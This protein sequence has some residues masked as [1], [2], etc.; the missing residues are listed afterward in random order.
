MQ[1]SIPFAALLLTPLLA[2][3]VGEVDFTGKTCEQPADCP[4][5]YVCASGVC[6]KTGQD[7]SQADGGSV[8]AGKQN[9]APT[10]TDLRQLDGSGRAV[11]PGATVKASPTLAAAPIDP[12]GGPVRLE[13]EL[14]P[15]T[16][17]FT[18]TPNF[19][20][21]YATSGS[22]A[23]SLGSLEPGN[24]RWQARAV[25]AEGN[26]SAFEPFNG[27]ATAFT[28]QPH[29][30][31]ASLQIED[32]AAFARSSLVTLRLQASSRTGATITGVQLSNDNEQFSPI[33]PFASVRPGWKLEAGDGPRRVYARILDSAGESVVVEAAVVVDSTPPA[34]ALTVGDGT[35][36]ARVS[37]VS[38]LIDATDATSGLATMAFSNDGQGFSTP[39]PFEASATWPLVPGDGNRK[40]TVR[41]ADKAGNVAEASASVFFDA[42]PPTGTLTINGGAPYT[43]KRDV[44]LALAITDASGPATVALSQDGVTFG[45]E[46]PF[47]ASRTLTLNAGEGQKRVWARVVDRAGNSAVLEGEIVLDETPPGITDFQVNGGAAFTSKQQVELTFAASDALSGVG[48]LEV[49]EGSRVTPVGASPVAYSLSQGDGAR[50]LTLAVVDKAGNS[51]TASQPIHLDTARPSIPQ[52]LLASP[53][54]RAVVLE[55]T[56]STD[57]GSGVKGYEVGI[58]PNATGPFVFEP[59]TTEQPPLTQR[60]LRND[61]SWYFVVRAVDHAGNV[62]AQSQMVSAT[63][64]F[65]FEFQ[66]RLPAPVAWRG[67]AHFSSRDVVLVGDHGVVVRSREQFRQSN[68]SARRDSGVDETLRGAVYD[69]QSWTVA[70]GDRGVITASDDQGNTWTPQLNGS[71]RTD[72]LHA[73]AALPAVNTGERQF[74]AV[75]AGG[76]AVSGV[77][78]QG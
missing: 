56:P 58:A 67:A 63:P 66:H 68:E 52:G 31:D 50:T 30:I 54:S 76:V 77:L 41:I 2:C 8:D 71:G 64:R 16:S 78:K 75:G 1:R 36:F 7:P 24:Y 59:L 73:V 57:A 12:E 47:L 28:L 13:V 69:G 44:T 40:V 21:E 51:A 29:A 33:E 35:G 11:A 15:S 27:G 25:D 26:A 6:V 17:P 60:G 37:P 61:T 46:E 20:G 5:G 32:G 18:G 34:V 42:T 55:F 4:A 72:A 39:A 53:R 23:V 14:V 9:L 62:S 43:S 22:G 38:L 70:V 74:I 3:T 49:R 65:A 48:R 10:L 19:A 45:P